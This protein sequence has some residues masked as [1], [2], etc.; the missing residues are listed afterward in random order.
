M[1]TE[2][3]KLLIGGFGK[4]RNENSSFVMCI[5]LSVSPSV[6]PFTRNNSAPTGRIFVKFDI[7]VLF[8]KSVGKLQI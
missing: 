3:D 6:L 2:Q 4:S 7:R 5:L 1:N 8:E